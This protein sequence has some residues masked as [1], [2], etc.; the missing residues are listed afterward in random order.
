MNILARILAERNLTQGQ[1]SRMTGITRETICA[2]ANGKNKLAYPS[3]LAALAWALEIDP[4]DLDEIYDGRRPV[5][6]GPNP[7]LV[8]AGKAMTLPGEPLARAIRLHLDR[9]P[10]GK[11]GQIRLDQELP[12]PY[13]LKGQNVR[14]SRAEQVCSKLGIY[15]ADIYGLAYYAAGGEA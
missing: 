3:H 4:Y 14:L 6:V 2:I 11:R 8:P 9:V 15:P 12:D 13:A 10:Y 7:H 5:P 1:L